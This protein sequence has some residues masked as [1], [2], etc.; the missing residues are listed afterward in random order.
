MSRSKSKTGETQAHIAE[1]EP[2]SLAK[3]ACTEAQM[4]ESISTHLNGSDK[5]VMQA[6]EQPALKSALQSSTPYIIGAIFAIIGSFITSLVA[7]GFIEKPATQSSVVE[8]K[9]TLSTYI[10]HH[11]QIH[12]ITNDALKSQLNTIQHSIETITDRLLVAPPAGEK[13]RRLE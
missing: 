1:H 2:E 13:R 9:D 8:L 10:S 4:T 5:L 7:S 12:I 11:D 3:S 6:T